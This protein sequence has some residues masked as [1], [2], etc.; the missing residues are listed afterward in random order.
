MPWLLKWQEP[1]SLLSFLCYCTSYHGLCYQFIENYAMIVSQLTK[2]LVK[3]A[4]SEQ[5]AEQ[6][7]V[8]FFIDVQV[9]ASA[10]VLLL[11]HKEMN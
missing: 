4:E 7:D 10:S 1:L 11:C 8:F 9:L 6:K 2:C 5:E 3:Y